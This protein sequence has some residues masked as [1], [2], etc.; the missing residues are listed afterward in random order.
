VYEEDKED[1][2][3]LEDISRCVVANNYET[4]VIKISTRRVAESENIVS[5]DRRERPQ[6]L[7]FD[8]EIPYFKHNRSKAEE[9][10]TEQKVIP[11]FTPRDLVTKESRY[12]CKM[13]RVFEEFLVIEGNSKETI[14]V[15]QYPDI[16][17]NVNSKLRRTL[18]EFCFPEDKATLTATP[19]V[20]VLDDKDTQGKYL[21]C[22]CLKKP[23]N[24]RLV[25]DV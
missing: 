3:L 24:V 18:K 6:P 2:N 25:I 14:N 19:F 15:F 5:S 23:L 12:E 16:P 17:L 9:V 1:N 7:S 20:L 22:I 4:Q 21:Y 8:T 10:C 13:N 11:I